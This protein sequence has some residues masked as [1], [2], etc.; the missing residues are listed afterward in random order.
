[1]SRNVKAK[2]GLSDAIVQVSGRLDAARRSKLLRIGATVEAEYPSIDAYRIKLPNRSLAA[3][4]NLPWVRR[5]SDNCTVQK[6][7]V[8]TTTH[9]LA[10]A[11]W[12]SRSGNYGTGVNI[13]IV[14]SGIQEANDFN[15][16][17]EKSRVL[18]HVDFAA[19]SLD[20]LS[21]LLLRDPC[22]HG[23]HVAGIAAGNGA[24]SSGA[25]A[26]ATYRGQAP[27]ANLIG[28]RVLERDGSGSVSNVLAGLEWVLRN[29]ST[30]N[31]RIVNLSLGHAAG[32]SYST[33]P[34]CLMVEKLWK[35]GIV[36]VCAA[37]NMGRLNET[38]DSADSEYDN[39][40]WGTAYGSI[41]VP[42]NSPYAITV[43]AMKQTAG[44][45]RSSDRIATYSSRGPSPFDYVLKPD[46][47]APGNQVISVGPRAGYLYNN[48]PGNFIP[49]VQ[50][51]KD[52]TQL[53]PGANGYYVLSGTSMAAPV[54]SG[55]VAMM[56]N[57]APWLNPD[58]I[59][60]RLMVSADRWNYGGA[61][62]SV[63]GETDPYTFG[64]GFLNVASALKSTLTPKSSAVSPTMALDGNGNLVFTTSSINPT[65][66]GL[67]GTGIYD[68]G[69]VY[70]TR[71]VWGS[72]STTSGTRAV[73]GTNTGRADGTRAV[74]GTTTYCEG[75]RAV[76]GSSGPKCDLTSVAINGER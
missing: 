52:P 43:G 16:S 13:A 59:K 9:T 35:N 45:S 19:K 20:L 23:T 68:P 29:R 31:I 11:G 39:E 15:D 34:L 72:G 69:Q 62:T 58:T 51:L 65:G 3:L 66:T 14:D 37:G 25:N 30:W 44:G 50:Y 6:S 46:L 48:Y 32:E 18:H 38:L 4:A 7:D 61:E 21:E 53:L 74:W 41:Q 73:W 57:K 28:V 24:S 63:K 64:A 17:A 26:Y 27:N 56:L 22:G 2:S 75:T 33:D 42:G 1:M 5:I 71:A 40:G 54:V 36:V 60:A 8:F 70:G 47:V 10:S 55:T 76:W 12:S 67:W 49:L